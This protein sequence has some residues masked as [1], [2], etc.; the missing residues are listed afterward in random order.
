MVPNGNLL[1]TDRRS[2]DSLRPQFP[3]AQPRL[4][5]AGEAEYRQC[6]ED[7]AI[8]LPRGK[9]CCCASRETELRRAPRI[10]DTAVQRRH[11][12]RREET[13]IP[14]CLPLKAAKLG[15]AAHAA[16]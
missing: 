12:P 5:G 15:A 16:R 3:F 4:C 6:Q 14:L 1:V 10:R 9:D 2:R 7:C 11:G 13:R 8:L